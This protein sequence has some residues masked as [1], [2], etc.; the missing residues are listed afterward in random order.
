MAVPNYWTG[1]LV[2]GDIVY[3][4]NQDGTLSQSK[5]TDTNGN[6]FWVADIVKPFSKT[7]A[8]NGNGQIACPGDA[9]NNEIYK[10]QC[11]RRMLMDV[12]AR[13]LSDSQVISMIAALN[14]ISGISPGQLTARISR[15]KLEKLDILSL[16]DNEI[17]YILAGMRMAGTTR[18]KVSK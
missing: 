11:R 15:E 9:F 18:A 8:R 14:Y 4:L 1:D 16:S 2:K 10:S 3:C 12:D 7:T 6:C 5:V 17:A 13:S